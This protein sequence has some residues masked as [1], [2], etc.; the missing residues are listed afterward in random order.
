M[1][2]AQIWSKHE[3]ALEAAEAW[4]E[5]NGIAEVCKPKNF[6]QKVPLNKIYD[7]GG[8]GYLFLVPD[9]MVLSELRN[10]AAA[11]NAKKLAKIATL[12][13]QIQALKGSIVE[14]AQVEIEVVS[15][16]VSEPVVHHHGY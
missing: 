9:E 7:V 3:D 6:V 4:V 5:Q 10:H 15:T 2:Q 16:P 1:T 14:P 12:E 11:L 13:D 8:S